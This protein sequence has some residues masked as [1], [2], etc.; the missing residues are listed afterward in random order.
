MLP[1][2]DKTRFSGQDAQIIDLI[3]SKGGRLR[4]SK[5]AKPVVVGTRTVK[6]VDLHIQVYVYEENAAMAAYVWRVLVFF[7]STDSAHQC[8]PVLAD[9]YIDKDQRARADQLV[10]AIMDG[11]STSEWNGVNRWTGAL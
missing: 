7:L 5:P 4:R 2:I 6:I 9:S 11:I 8:L 10:N 3:T 1:T